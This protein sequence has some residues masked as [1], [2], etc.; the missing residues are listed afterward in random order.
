MLS[1]ARLECRAPPVAGLPAT[2]YTQT[3][4]AKAACCGPRVVS[5]ADL[6]RPFMVPLSPYIPV[7]GVLLA[8]A[9]IG[10]LPW[11]AWVR[12][13][14]WLLLGAVMWLVYGSNAPDNGADSLVY[15]R[16]D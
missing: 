5:V 6:P 2:P 8:I 7:L 16:V 15:D 3:P 4:N 14:A 13:V 11:T 9:Q 10:F 1:A 12:M